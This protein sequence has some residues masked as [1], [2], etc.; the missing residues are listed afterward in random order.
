[1]KKIKNY[2]NG[3]LVD[4]TNKRFINNF[5]PSTGKKYSLIPDSQKKDVLLAVDS[6]K[7]AFVTWS[8]KTKKERYELL[9]CLANNIDLNFKKLV[10]A[11]SFDTGKPE[12]L[13]KSVDIPRC[14]E[15]IKFFATASLHFDSKFHEMDGAAINYTLKEPVGVVGAISPWNLPLYLLTW[16]IA[17]ALAAG[18]TVIAKPSEITPYTA[19]LFSKI[20]IKSGIPPGVIN[21]VHGLGS[22]VGEEIVKHK[23]VPIITFTG[24]TKT[25]RRIASI[26]AKNFKK[27][28]LELGG[29]NPNI[30]FS[31]T[32]IKKAVEW[33]IKSSFL[34]QGQVCLCGSRLFVEKTIYN[35]F[36]SLF[37]KRTLDLIVGDPK[38]EESFLGSV[39][40]QN[41][42]KN[43]LKKISEAK[44]LGGKVLVGGK[45]KLL[46][47]KFKN[48][49]FLEPTIIENLSYL[50]KT[51]QEEIFGPVVCL[52]PF[53]TEDEVVKMA[54]STNYGLSASVFTNNISRGH[55]VAAKIKSG[56]VWINSWLI[57]DLRIPFGGMKSSGLG[58]EGGFGSL[59]FFTEQKNVC[60]KIDSEP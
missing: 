8:K 42:M 58:R 11:E 45:R 1:M 34:N 15:N 46:N 9:M 36:K 50:S 16:K 31:D 57:R 24:G 10:Q 43:I 26:A 49:Y 33:A 20:C 48:G 37:V 25:G 29:K 22:I 38:K 54:N 19:F 27:L 59:D 14:S 3:K 7:K 39:V 51:N 28:S 18:N 12:W 4:S 60:L 56:I 13:T 47:G 53:D 6:A 2:I 17:P 35:E 41:H 5:N 55:R 52:I 21:I 44:K 32:D 40:S 30:V 23:D